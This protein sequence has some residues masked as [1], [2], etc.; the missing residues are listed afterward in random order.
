MGQLEVFFII[1]AKHDHNRGV[2]SGKS[3]IIAQRIETVVADHV[4]ERIINDHIGEGII[5]GIIPLREFRIQRIGPVSSA[6]MPKRCILQ[7]VLERRIHVQSDT[8]AN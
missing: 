7:L 6:C 8:A 1:T 3:D 4:F 5:N 2:V